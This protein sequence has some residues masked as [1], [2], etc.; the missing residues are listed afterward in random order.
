M[1]SRLMIQNKKG[2]IIFFSSVATI[3]NEV[4]TS[5]YASSKSG[6]ETFSQTIK[7]ELDKL[8]VDKDFFKETDFYVLDF[9]YPYLNQNLKPTHV[10]FNEFILQKQIDYNLKLYE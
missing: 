7:K 2:L 1:L 5:I 3:I 4:G 9:N 6:V 8:L 10:N